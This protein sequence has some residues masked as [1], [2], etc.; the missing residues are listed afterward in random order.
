MSGDP[1]GAGGVA[2]FA[3]RVEAGAQADERIALAR[4][5]DRRKSDLGLF[6]IGSGLDFVLAGREIVGRA[7]RQPRF[8]GEGFGAGAGERSPGGRRSGDSR[9]SRSDEACPLAKA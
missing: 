1:S 8:E 2:V 5:V 4:A 9:A 3:A 7:K 6:E